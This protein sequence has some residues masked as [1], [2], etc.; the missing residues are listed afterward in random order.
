[1]SHDASNMLPRPLPVRASVPLCLGRVYLDRK[2]R[3]L[4]IDAL[5]RSLGFYNQLDEG[6]GDDTGIA[7][8]HASLGRALINSGDLLSARDHL[9]RAMG[10]GRRAGNVRLRAEAHYLLGKVDWKEGDFEGAHYNWGRAAR[11]A[12]ETSD[13]MLRGRVQ[14]QQALILYTE[15]KLKEAIPVYQAAIQQIESASNIR[16]L[17][18]AYSSL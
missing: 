14:M 1:K 2:Q 15:G 17:L 8:A 9:H 10:T 18:K 5:E 6:K 7:G 4:A 16:L 12:E 13:P 11:L 3:E